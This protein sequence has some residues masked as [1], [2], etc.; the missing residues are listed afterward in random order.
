V[1][2]FSR[3]GTVWTQSEKLSPAAGAAGD[4]FGTCV[5]LFQNLN[6]GIGAPGRRIGGSVVGA[7]YKFVLRPTGWTQNKEFNGFSGSGFGT[8]VSQNYRTLLAGAELGN[9]ANPTTGT[10]NIYVDLPAKV[11]F[12]V[13]V[14]SD[15]VTGDELGTSIAQDICWIV[16]G[17]P[18][19]DSLGL[20]AGA[21][22]VYDM[23]HSIIAPIA[24]SGVN[25][26]IL[27][28]QAEFPAVI[29]DTWN[30]D[31]DATTIPGAASTTVIGALK[32]QAAP[33]PLVTG[34]LLIDLSSGVAFVSTTIGSGL[35]THSIAV[36]DNPW[37]LGIEI[38]IQA[39][40]RDAG[41]AILTLTNA[42]T[43]RIGCSPED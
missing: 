6:A 23:T 4:A 15:G 7:A 25:P 43:V 1:Y 16:I 2:S 5:S 21:A 36:P 24:G 13:L 18:G 26:A 14:A 31:V 37:L 35:N 12:D 32:P 10:S 30:I 28:T 8:A 9:N 42:E 33:I 40:V 39:A 41:S 29:G 19:Q 27:A 34:E 17:A 11:G 22:Y 20:D 38:S 3:T